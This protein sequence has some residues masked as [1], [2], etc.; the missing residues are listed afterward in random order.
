M[1]PDDSLRATLGLSAIGGGAFFAVYSLTTKLMAGQPVHRQDIVLAVANVAAAVLSGVLVAYFVGP[2]LAS[3][4]PLEGLREPHAL[5]FGIG[6][7]T[8]EGAPF[9]YRWLRI[10]AAS[11][12]GGAA[13]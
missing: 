3:L 13:Q 4:I 10:F 9:A 1:P 5:G 8:W 7:V 6:A 12:T 11:K 2:A